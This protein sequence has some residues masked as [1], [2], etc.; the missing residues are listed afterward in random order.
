MLHLW[1]NVTPVLQCYT[2]VKMLHVCYNV[3]P[4]LQCY[5]CVTMLHV[6]FQL[7][8]S[9]ESLVEELHYLSDQVQYADP[10]AANPDA[11]REQMADNNVSPRLFLV[12]DLTQECHPKQHYR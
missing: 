1:Y 11:L 10:I 3:T 8:D 5:T 6:V 7:S 12:V 4:V 2:C 9:L